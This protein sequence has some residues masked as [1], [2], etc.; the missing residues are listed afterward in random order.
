M[1][2][3][4]RTSYALVRITIICEHYLCETR[5][6]FCSRKVNAF[7]SRTQYQFVSTVVFERSIRVDADSIGQT[8]SWRSETHSHQ[9]S[10]NATFTFFLVCLHMC[11]CM[12]ISSP[13]QILTYNCTP[14]RSISF[15]EIFDTAR[16]IERVYCITARRIVWRYLVSHLRFYVAFWQTLTLPKTSSTPWEMEIEGAATQ[17]DRTTTFLTFFST[18]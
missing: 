14:I 1:G 15:F 5:I 6:A 10:C 3:A 8:H 11:P 9:Y 7:K 13:H 4:P 16:H 17:L 12:H 18:P 2:C